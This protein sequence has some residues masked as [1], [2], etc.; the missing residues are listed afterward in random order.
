[1]SDLNN[2]QLEPSQQ[3]EHSR[4]SGEPVDSRTKSK[5]ATSYQENPIITKAHSLISPAPFTS[6][7]H[8]SYIVPFAALDYM[9]GTQ[10]SRYNVSQTIKLVGLNHISFDK[11]KLNVDMV[12]IPYS[13]IW[14]NCDSFIAQNRGNLLSPIPSEAPCVLPSL[15]SVSIPPVGGGVSTP[16]NILNHAMSKSQISHWLYGPWNPSNNVKRINVLPHRAYIAMTNDI[17]R[18]KR[19]TPPSPEFNQNTVSIAEQNS[20]FRFGADT[21]I[22]ALFDDSVDYGI[23][24]LRRAPTTKNYWNTWRNT[25]FS[26]NSAV[27]NSTLFSHIVTQQQ[28]AEFRSQ[29]SNAGL[30]DEEVVSKI[31]GSRLA[32]ENMCYIIG[33]R[34]VDIDMI[35]QPQTSESDSSSIPLGAD[36]AYSYTFSDL[37]LDCNNFSAPRDGILMPVY[38][39]TAPNNS[40]S[41]NMRNKEQYKHDWRE[42][43]R[44][45]LAKI[46][47]QQYFNFEHDVTLPD[48]DSIRGFMR[49]YAEYF[50]H[51]IF[52]RGD[53]FRRGAFT[54]NVPRLRTSNGG[55]LAMSLDGTSVV[56]LPSYLDWIMPR[57]P[58][59]LGNLG[60][61]N[62]STDY[63]DYNI[64]DMVIDRGAPSLSHQSWQSRTA[65]SFQITGTLSILMRQ[66]VLGIIED[67]YVKWGEE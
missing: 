52:Y 21:M 17:Y 63:T 6:S 25:V 44:P 58:E 66:P 56:T 16:I 60:I 7:T 38:Y 59:N 40:F 36:G 55:F 19:F 46:K 45:D 41:Q 14:Q 15:I 4:V 22:P 12:Y 50:R 31:R 28:V 39:I 23:G 57:K 13:R 10:V 43:Y 11:L 62:P 35:V 32:K 9:A 34:S 33:H 30:T 61:L 53:F 42:Y 24:T 5:T 47:D 49:R 8:G 1:M 48:Q 51:P 20:L 54:T 29:S 18:E 26:D 2:K 3:M 37:G 65:Y 67:Q 27:D 64:R